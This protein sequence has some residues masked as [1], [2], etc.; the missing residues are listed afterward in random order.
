MFDL[1]DFVCNNVF[2]YISIISNLNQV[3]TDYSPQSVG[4]GNT[5]ELSG[6]LSDLHYSV[7][8][9]RALSRAVG[10]PFRSPHL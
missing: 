10:V 2:H 1:I 5:S 3:K 7:P 9:A 6:C 4:R 8:D